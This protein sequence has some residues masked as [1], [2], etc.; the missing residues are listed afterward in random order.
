MAAAEEAKAAMAQVAPLAEVV[1]Q[2][3]KIHRLF[4]DLPS[5]RRR[6]QQEQ[7]EREEEERWRHGQAADLMR[8]VADAQEDTGEVAAEEDPLSQKYHALLEEDSVEGEIWSRLEEELE[9]EFKMESSGAGDAGDQPSGLGRGGDGEEDGYQDD[10]Y[11]DDLELELEAGDEEG[12]GEGGAAVAE[13]ESAGEGEGEGGRGR[14]GGAE[15]AEDEDEAE[16]EIGAVDLLNSHY[17]H[18][19]DNDSDGG[20]LRDAEGQFDFLFH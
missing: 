9:E 3:M 18:L 19:L 7:R 13:G 12:G 20:S 2:G 17:H 4:P 15:Q 1:L 8:G 10:S 14:E 6:Q 5:R 11:E 16:A